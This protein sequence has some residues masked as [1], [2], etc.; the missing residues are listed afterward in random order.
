MTTHFGFTYNSIIM[1][2]MFLYTCDS[3]FKLNKYNG[4]IKAKHWN[5]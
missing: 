4:R 2:I 5:F 3:N 1:W